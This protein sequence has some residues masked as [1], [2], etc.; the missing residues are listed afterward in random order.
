[1]SAR[2]KGFPAEFCTVDEM[3]FTSVAGGFIL[4]LVQYVLRLILLS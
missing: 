1:M 2:I 3:F 4:G